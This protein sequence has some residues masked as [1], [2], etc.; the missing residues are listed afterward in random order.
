M[1]VRRNGGTQRVIAGTDCGWDVCGNQQDGCGNFVQEAAIS[2]RRYSAHP[3]I[4]AI[5]TEGNY[6]N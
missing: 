5:M 4:V 2:G 3:A 1:S 6:L